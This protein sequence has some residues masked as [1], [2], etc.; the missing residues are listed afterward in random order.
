MTADSEQEK[1]DVA[2]EKQQQ[3]SLIASSGLAAATV[4]ATPSVVGGP[5]V[6]NATTMPESI[7]VA[8][9]L[10]PHQTSA[11]AAEGALD[12]ITTGKAVKSLFSIPFSESGTTTDPSKQKPVCLAIHNFDGTLIIDQAEDE[13]NYFHSTNDAATS[14][15]ATPPIDPTI[16][17]PHSSESLALA[18]LPKDSHVISS[19]ALSLLSNIVKSTKDAQERSKLSQHQIDNSNLLAPPMAPREYVE[20]R[21]QDMNLLVGSDALIVRPTNNNNQVD[22]SAAS[23][24]GSTG[25]AVRVEEVNDLRS[26]W[27]SFQRKEQLLLQ[28]QPSYAQALSRDTKA[29]EAETAS[30]EGSFSETPLQTCVIPSSGPFGGRFLIE[31][32]S[33]MRS[34]GDVGPSVP[35]E[36]PSVDPSVP[37]STTPALSIVLDAYLDNLMAN[38][39][40][41]ALC[42][43]EKGLVQSIKFLQTEE[44]PSMMIHPSTLGLSSPPD[45]FQKNKRPGKAT[46]FVDDNNMFSPQIM[47]MNASALLRFLKANCT[48]NNTTYLLRHEPSRSEGSTSLPQQQNIQL[49]DISSLSTQGQ[50]KWMWWLATM[51]HRFALRLR[52]LE[53]ASATA[54]SMSEAQKRTIR[55]RERSLFQQTLDLLQDLQDMDGNAHESLVASVREHMADTYLGSEAAKEHVEEVV[56]PNHCN[57][58]FSASGALPS[59]KLP[60]HPL[61]ATGNGRQPETYQFNDYKNDEDGYKHTYGSVS[62]D[63]LNKVQDHLVHGIKSLAPLFEEVK[64]L[65]AEEECTTEPASRRRR[66]RP[67]KPENTANTTNTSQRVGQRTSLALSPATVLQMFGMNHKLVH[68][69]LRLADHHLKN[70]YSS[71]AMQALR[72]S[73]RRLA[74]AVELMNL[75][76]SGVSTAR[77]AVESTGFD[78]KEKERSLLLQYVMLLQYCGY[79]AR[80]FAFDEKWRDRGHASGEDVISVLREVEAALKSDRSGTNK[81]TLGNLE[82]SD[83]LLQKSHGSASL[84]SLSGVVAFDCSDSTRPGSAL[85]AAEAVLEEERVLQLERRR[86]LVASCVCYSRALAAFRSLMVGVL[87]EQVEEIGGD[88]SPQMLNMLLKWLGDACNETGSALTQSLH[89]FLGKNPGKTNAQVQHTSDQ[90]LFS[91][92]FWFSMA[93]EAFKGCG[94]ATNLALVRCNICLSYRIEANAVFAKENATSKHEETCLQKATEELAKAHDDLGQRDV[95]PCRWDMVSKELGNAL[96]T[97]GMRRRRNLLG[98]ET[99]L[100]L[101]PST[102]L[103]AGE[104]FLVLDPFERAL[105]IYEQSG[106]AAQEAASHYQLAQ[107]LSKLW[108]CH[109]LDENVMRKKPSPAVDQRDKDFSRKKLASALDHYRLA[110]EYYSTHL[111]GNETTFCLLCQDL[112]SLYGAIPGEFG[113]VMAVGCC[114][115]SREAFSPDSV[116]AALKVPSTESQNRWLDQMTEVAQSVEKRLF[117][118]L[119]YL[120]KANQSR[121]MDL[122]REGLSAKFAGK[123]PEDDELD[124]NPQIV[125][126]LTLH[127]VLTA[128]KQKYDE[129]RASV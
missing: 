26:A 113:L 72:T 70:Y 89:S 56:Q 123:V 25:V 91:A 129:V 23:S 94:D 45:P 68:V 6:R 36:E 122:Y 22:P 64:G 104:E 95:D 9:I 109:R 66:K 75:Y 55:D 80:S 49:Y 30:T 127:A 1:D 54:N 105:K 46:S 60:P 82:E 103:T 79:F 20:W 114:L 99:A 117:E 29:I 98:G 18:L 119:R 125:P 40:Q 5:S 124:G 53:L 116:K 74:E 31:S 41:L 83:A 38:V 48:R 86:V 118:L 3:L 43:Q 32:S 7:P 108:T 61:N 126:I 12:F 128:I 93:L 17:L 90:L 21:F 42:L 37:A 85:K 84:R 107:T 14:H 28:A 44:I 57:G 92:R 51:S 73:A 19:E 101:L 87:Q 88:K 112:A 2:G 102:K 111:R 10:T 81:F 100:V 76:Q 16:L 50:K 27:Q 52:H 39:P 35:E 65:A 63:A 62:V 11:S 78:I 106:N 47:E 24:S 67:G 97:L 4:A 71:S 58:S 13:E 33:K 15:L 120:A 115:D 34:S 8:D 59:A 121:Y 69:S 96:L 110:F 77:N